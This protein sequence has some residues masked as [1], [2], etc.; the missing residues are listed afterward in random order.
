MRSGLEGIVV[1]RPLF[2]LEEILKLFMG[3][4]LSDECEEQAGCDTGN[5]DVLQA[6]EREEVHQ[7]G[8]VGDDEDGDDQSHHS[9]QKAALP[10]G[11]QNIPVAGSS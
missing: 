6:C 5:A 3:G 10:H 8:A 9:A 7:A 2:L 4:G 1:F 11:V